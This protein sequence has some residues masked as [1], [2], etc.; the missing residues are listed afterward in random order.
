M[1][2]KSASAD[3]QSVLFSTL[4]ELSPPSLPIAIGTSPKGEGVFE[5]H[6]ALRDKKGGKVIL[7]LNLFFYS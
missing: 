7:Q 5:D 6:P 1:K 3:L 2:H 4:I